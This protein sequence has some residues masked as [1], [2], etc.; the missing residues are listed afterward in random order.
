[1]IK[2]IYILLS[3][4]H[5]QNTDGRCEIREAKIFDSLSTCQSTIVQEILQPSRTVGSLHD[6]NYYR[7]STGY[8]ILR[9]GNSIR[10]CVHAHLPGMRVTLL[11]QLECGTGIGGI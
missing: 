9:S 4:F 8:R 3:L 11:A 5:T 1:M 7:R 2:N 10:Q 6:T